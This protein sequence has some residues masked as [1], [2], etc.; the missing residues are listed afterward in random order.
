VLQI[1]LDHVRSAAPES[2]WR[3]RLMPWIQKMSQLMRHGEAPTLSAG[4]PIDQ[5]LGVVVSS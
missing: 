4:V 2:F 1:G 5:D 3:S